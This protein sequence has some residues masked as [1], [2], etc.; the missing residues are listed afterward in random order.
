MAAPTADRYSPEAATPVERAREWARTARPFAQPN[1]T[2]GVL[3]LLVTVLPLIG[4]WTAMMLAADGAWW[5]TLLLAIPAA[6]FMVRLFII[7]H[8][9][10]HRS[11]FRSRRLNDILGNVLGI[12]TLTPHDYWRRAHNIHHSTCGDLDGRGIGDIAL[13][14]VAEYTA[15]PAWRRFIYRIYRHPLVM[16]GIG[17]VYVFMIKHRLPL[18][19]IRQQ[20]RVLINVMITNL[21]IAA[22]L[23]GLGFWLGFVD[24]LIVQAA[25]VALSGSAGIWL[26]Y[27]QHQFEHT[28]WR[29]RENWEFHE[30]SVMASSFY[31]LPQPLR[32]LSGNIGIH[33]LHH[34]SCRIPSYRLGACLAE[35]PAL[36]R[37]NRIGLR[38]SLAGLN[39]TLWDENT[40]R[41]ISFRCLR[42]KGM[43]GSDGT[44]D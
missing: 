27:V 6:A 41:L 29:K 26:F 23:T 9:C 35:I 14:T 20:P 42:R 2:H 33:H 16:F 19:L 15:L 40:E 21:G 11:Y 1:A 25:I 36:Q 24:V 4:L 34:L 37:L 13:L 10:G 28:Y 30:A 8:D 5:L 12:F 44:P 7:Q 22:V 32:W 17:P 18:D 38:E 39:L 3:Q 43:A 31:D